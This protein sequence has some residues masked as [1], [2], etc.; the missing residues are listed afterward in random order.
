M[1]ICCFIFTLFLAGCTSGAPPLIQGSIPNQGATSKVKPTVQL[2][3]FADGSP[4]KE[5]ETIKAQPGQVVQLKVEMVRPDGSTTDVTNDAKTQYFSESPGALTVSSGGRL[6]ITP[7]IPASPGTIASV[8]IIYGKPGDRDIGA[9][10]VLFML[11]APNSA[12]KSLSLTAPKTELGVGES[13]QL[14]LVQKLSD[15]T[16]ADITTNPDVRYQTG[17]ESALVVEPGGRVTC[18]GTHGQSE[19]IV[20]ITAVYHNLSDA[21][22]FELHDKGPGSTLKVVVGDSTLQEAEHTKFSVYSTKGADLTPR[23]SGTQYLIFGGHGLPEPDLLSIDDT[24]GTITATKSIGRYNRRSVILFVRNG[25]LVGWTAI[26]LT[27]GS[28]MSSHSKP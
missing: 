19:D 27:H 20:S 15:G 1:R 24:S 28:M 16:T 4:V 17:S 9:T 10:S 12:A 8:G 18:I 25:D 14:Q 3:I 21:L 13:V 23:K 2:Q 6:V 11:P 5:G 22:T 26:R 7:G